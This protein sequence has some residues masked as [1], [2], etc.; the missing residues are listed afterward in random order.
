MSRRGFGLFDAELRGVNAFGRAAF[1]IARRVGKGGASDA[2][3]LHGR[4]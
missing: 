2:G 3:L 1:A 4:N